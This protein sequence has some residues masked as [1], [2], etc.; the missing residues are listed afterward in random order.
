MNKQKRA[1]RVFVVDDHPIVLTGV[2]AL[3]KDQPNITFIGGSTSCQEGLV[4]VHPARTDVLIL[5]LNIPG[6]DF[7][8][9]IARF[10]EHCPKAKILIF[11]AYYSEDLLKS[12]RK[13]GIAGFVHKNAAPGDLLDGILQVAQGEFYLCVARSIPQGVQVNGSSRSV[14]KDDFRKRL[15]LSRREEEI[16]KL[17]SR[18]LTSQHIG[19]MLYIS[20]HTVETHRKNILRKLNFNSSM[21]LVKFAVQ[22][23]LV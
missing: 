19:N 18:G 22:Q 23:G 10:K 20:K 14:L 12:L 13:E 4:K 15:L 17:I 5:D 7:R 8:N 21:E 16:L 2:E 3:L 1:I 9:N 6:E 11:S